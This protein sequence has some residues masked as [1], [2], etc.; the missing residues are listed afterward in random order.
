MRNSYYYYY[1]ETIII[2]IHIFSSLEWDLLKLTSKRHEQLYPGCCGQ[3]R[4]NEIFGGGGSR[5]SRFRLI[6]Q[7]AF[8]I[9]AKKTNQ[10][11]L[12]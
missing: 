12:E 3:V 6:P 8:R 5:Y 11:F 2:I 10:G 9:L 7:F 4:F 1:E